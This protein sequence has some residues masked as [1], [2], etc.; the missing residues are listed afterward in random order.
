MLLPQR[1]MSF[2]RVE[3]RPCNVIGMKF[4]FSVCRLVFRPHHHISAL[5]HLCLTPSQNRHSWFTASKKPLISA[6][7]RLLT[8]FYWLP[9]S[10]SITSAQVIDIG[11]MV[12][13]RGQH[14]IGIRSRFNAYP[15]EIWVHSVF[16]PCKVSVFPLSRMIERGTFHST[17][18]SRFIAKPGPVPIQRLI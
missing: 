7:T 15:V 17:G 11:D 13:E 1:H 6:S 18:D 12:I 16:T 9:L 5:H 8:R 14:Q 2:C 4:V 10:K 3:M